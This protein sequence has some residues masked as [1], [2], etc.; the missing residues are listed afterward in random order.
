MLG[1]YGL[2]GNFVYC[3]HTA[4]PKPPH[5]C[6]FWVPVL[7]FMDHVKISGNI[8]PERGGGG[9]GWFTWGGGALLFLG[10]PTII[11]PKHNKTGM[12]SVPRSLW[13]F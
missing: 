6:L 7:L 12:K 4:G 9:G 1:S 11:V 5:L 2:L 8:H 3:E 10:T 13:C